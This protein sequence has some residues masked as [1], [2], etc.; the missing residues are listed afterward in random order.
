MS[1]G[2]LVHV[3]ADALLV[4]YD[5]YTSEQVFKYIDNY[6]ITEKPELVVMLGAA[7]MP[8]YSKIVF[9]GRVWLVL[10]E[11]IFAIANEEKDVSRTS[12]SDLV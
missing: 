4:E 12:A 7:G 5:R 2:D 9:M 10:T 3:P 1:P 8:N 11:T 6:M